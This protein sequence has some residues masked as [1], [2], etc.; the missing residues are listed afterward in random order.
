MHCN[1]RPPVAAPV[2]NRFNNDA[3]AKYDVAQPICCRLIAFLLP[4]YYA[5]TLTF[6][7]VTSDREYF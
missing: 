3:H 6:N 7:S 5:V 4:I 2:L 1:L